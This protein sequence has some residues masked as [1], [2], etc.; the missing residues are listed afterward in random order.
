[1]TNIAN[2]FAA[3]L[4]VWFALLMALI[5]MRVLNGDIFVTGMLQQDESDTGVKPE[6]VV[7]MATFPAVIIAYAMTALHADVSSTHPILPDVPETLIS[8]L[9]GGNAIYLAGKIARGT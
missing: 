9:T 5:V 7:A 1:M 2:L 6:R 8:L 3:G 4:L